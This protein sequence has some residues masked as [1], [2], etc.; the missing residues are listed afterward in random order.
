MQRFLANLHSSSDNTTWQASILVIV[1]GYADA[2][3]FLTFGAFAG[4]MTGNTVL[5][6]IALA[7]RDFGAAAQ[8]AIIIASF[9][10][11]VAAS[12][13]LGRRLP[14][15]AI[16]GIEAVAIVVAA[17]IAPPVAAPVLAFAM[18]LQNATMT[19]FAG[20]SL[21]TVF[22][23]GNLQKMMQDFLGRF[24]G[25]TKPLQSEAAEGAVIGQLWIAY[26]GGVVAGALAHQWIT[27]PLLPVVLL[28]PLAL[29]RRALWNGRGDS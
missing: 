27:Y 13:I 16:L 8:S 2:V 11:G 22:L 21:N 10:V 19:R 7:G 28:L 15:M 6:G 26:L 23:T 1:A 14:L 18:G 12:A 17:L 9:L 20:A 4:A 29:I 24:T 25:S 3:G 5:L